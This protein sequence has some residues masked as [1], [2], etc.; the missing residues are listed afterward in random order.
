MCS[1]ATDNQRRM[2]QVPPVCELWHKT[3]AGMSVARGIVERGPANKVIDKARDL[4]RAHDLLRE[5]D[6]TSAKV[7]FYLVAEGS[8]AGFP[9]PD[10]GPFRLI[11]RGPTLLNER[12]FE[13]VSSARLEGTLMAI[14]ETCAQRG[15]PEQRARDVLSLVPELEEELRHA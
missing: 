10:L 9:E 13:K 15:T 12:T 3:T 6:A 7:E 4:Y 11:E 14:A 5:R 1:F 8:Y 2:R